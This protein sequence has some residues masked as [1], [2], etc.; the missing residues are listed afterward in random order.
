MTLPPGQHA[1]DGFPRFGTHLNRPAPAV[2]ADPTIEIG[3]AGED[4]GVLPLAG[5]AG[6]SPPAAAGPPASAPPLTAPPPAGPADPTIEI[7]G[8]VND[9]V[10]LPLADLAGLPRRELV[11]DFHCVA[12][13]SATGLRWEGVAFETFYREV[14][15]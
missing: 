7:G 15:E 9:P 2:P 1:I 4:P 8:A 5:L 10:V 12:G 13:W 3:G 14:I 11:A 6:P